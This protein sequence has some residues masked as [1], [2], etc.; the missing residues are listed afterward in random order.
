VSSFSIL[1]II[2]DDSERESTVPDRPIRLSLNDRVQLMGKSYILSYL[3]W[4]KQ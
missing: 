4:L 2:G 1:R 3:S